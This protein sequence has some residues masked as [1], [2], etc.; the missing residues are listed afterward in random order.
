MSPRTPA[1][2][3]FLGRFP[4]LLVPGVRPARVGRDGA[5]GG[6]PSVHVW[7]G[8][9]VTIGLAAVPVGLLRSVRLL[10]IAL[11]TRG[12]QELARR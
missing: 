5:G 1:S 11:E 6:C 2:R 8:L 10:N 12:R 3:S 4:L 7:S 9:S